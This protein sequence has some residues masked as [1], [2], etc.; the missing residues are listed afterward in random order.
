[1][2]T[3]VKAMADNHL[4]MEVLIIPLIGCHDCGYTGAIDNECPKCG[5]DGEEKV[6]RIR[7]I[8]GYLVGTLKKW[9]SAKASEEEE[10]VKHQ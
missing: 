6:D 4:G 2:D 5:N 10:R 8:T 1:M 3:I 7:R 9:N